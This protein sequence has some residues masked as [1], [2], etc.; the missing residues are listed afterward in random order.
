MANTLIWCGSYSTCLT[1]VRFRDKLNRNDKGP[2]QSLL[3]S[4]CPACDEPTASVH[5]LTEETK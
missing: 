4:D 5:S 1:A 3:S 2:N